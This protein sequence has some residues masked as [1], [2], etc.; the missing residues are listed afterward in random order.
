MNEINLR[1]PDE[2]INFPIKSVL[3]LIKFGVIAGRIDF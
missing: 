3:A 1:N 2:D